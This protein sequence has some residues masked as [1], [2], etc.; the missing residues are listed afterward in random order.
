MISDSELLTAL[1]EFEA[2]FTKYCVERLEKN[3]AGCKLGVIVRRGRFCNS[4][5]MKLGDT[6]K[7]LQ[8]KGSQN[9]E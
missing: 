7:F 2:F 4:L 5:R 6:R 9:L 3:C 1:N 8:I